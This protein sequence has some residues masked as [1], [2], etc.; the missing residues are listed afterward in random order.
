MIVLVTSIF[1][2]VTRREAIGTIHR[3]FDQSS[4]FVTEKSFILWVIDD[5]AL[6]GKEDIKAFIIIAKEIS[7]GLKHPFIFLCTPASK[8]TAL[9]DFLLSVVGKQS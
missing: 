6:L 8:I 5:V 3:F 2:G 1:R 7:K 9:L 4:R